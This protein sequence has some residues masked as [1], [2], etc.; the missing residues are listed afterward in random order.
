MDICIWFLL[1]GEFF[2]R[3]VMEFEA[4][5]SCDHL[6]QNKEAIVISDN[7]IVWTVPSNDVIARVPC[8][9]RVQSH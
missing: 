2:G 1:W 4:S 9:A 6:V 3:C 7:V 8:F 5:Y